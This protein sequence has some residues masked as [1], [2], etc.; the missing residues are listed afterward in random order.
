MTAA[1]ICEKGSYREENQDSILIRQ[2]GRSGLFIVADGVGGSDDGRAASQYITERYGAWWE[3]Y[4]L[5]YPRRDF[6]S[7]FEDVKRLAEQINRE[8][9]QGHKNG[10][11]CSTVVL[12]F[13]HRGIFGYLS[14]GDSRIYRCGY[15]GVRRITRDD[16]WENC[17]D[18]ALGFGYEGKL[19]SAVGGYEALEYSCATD[20]VHWRDVFLLCSDGVY[21]YVEEEIL[22]KS[23]ERMR[24]TAFFK[25]QLAEEL[26]QRAVWNDTRDNY[27]LIAVRI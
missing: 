19:M 26:A 18:A 9:Y 13:V 17:P 2:D 5:A 15:G 1:G 21:K 6:F 14:V 22:L 23:L 10:L 24:R 12:L 25:K 8:I 20:Q 16:V 4:F 7:L 11:C 27:S 3:T